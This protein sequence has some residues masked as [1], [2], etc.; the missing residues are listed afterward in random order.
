M[1]N[2]STPSLLLPALVG[3]LALWVGGVGLPEGALS[4][5]LG[6]EPTDV[7]NLKVALEPADL[8]AG[9][10][11]WLVLTGTLGPTWHI[12]SGGEGAT[13]W[14]PIAAQG[15]TY[16]LGTARTSEP[17]RW[18]P[19]WGDE[20]DARDV[21]EGQFTLRV[22]VSLAK[23][24]APGTEL[25]LALTYN[26][27]NDKVCLPTV[28]GR[29]A[30]I[31][32]GG[33]GVNGGRN[34][35]AGAPAGV[36]ARPPM[37]SAPLIASGGEVRLEVEELASDGLRGVLR[38]TFTPALNHHFYLPPAGEDG[39]PI[40][41][42]PLAASGVTWGAFALPQSG[43]KLKEPLVA[44]LA[45]TRSQEAQRLSV[46][47]AFQACDAF[48]YCKSPEDAVLHVEFGS[49]ADAPAPGTSAPASP[50]GAGDDGTLFFEV[51]RGDGGEGPDGARPSPG[52]GA[53]PVAAAGDSAA[54]AGDPAEEEGEVADLFRTHGFWALGLI[55]LIGIGLAFTP[56]VL[57]IIP[58]TISVIGGGRAIPRGRLT[59]LLCTYVGGLALTYGTVG[60]VS[61]FAGGSMS[62]AFREPL[63]IYAIAGFFFFLAMAMLGIFELQPPQW[64][65]R[66]QGGAQRRSGSFIGAFM[67]GCLAAVIASPCTGPFIAGMAVFTA[68]Q[69]DPALGF[70]MFVSMALGMGAVFF[71]AGSLNLVM[72]PGPWMVWVRYVFGLILFGAAIYYLGNQQLLVPP[73]SYVV[74]GIGALVTIAGITRHLAHREGAPMAEAFRRGLAVGS[75]MLVTGLLVAWMVRPLEVPDDLQWTKLKDRAQLMAAV[76]EAAAAGQPVVVDVWA[77]WCHYCKEYDK[78]MLASDD[79]RDRLRRVKRLKLD[80]TNDNFPELRR[81]LGIPRDAQPYL[82]FMDSKKRIHADASIDQW[83][84]DQSAARLTESLDR[85]LGQGPAAPSDAPAN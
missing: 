80:V 29:R 13:S 85:V 15:V 18:K 50:P 66:L 27:C 7:L 75:M 73:V 61:A 68:Q 48:G 52:E 58:I 31:A 44:R 34:A 39:L 21:W 81:G 35:A 74:A 83:H 16:H 45:F 24:V 17:H 84:G 25:G 65:A 2:R 8:E 1:R 49:A 33:G 46:R 72:R 59:G 32:L 69:Q 5:A 54:G 76:D 64:L 79:L 22:K 63:V 77:T 11:G 23:D 53:S 42:E 20:S 51:V 55:F 6:G 78:V 4:S 37:A 41:A 36:V 14:E 70:A 10:D 40:E 56:C 60:L 30:V 28:K 71:A 38:L 82:V 67:F 9:Q 43:G 62:A 47:V 26:P 19:D 57:P 12:Y 3:V